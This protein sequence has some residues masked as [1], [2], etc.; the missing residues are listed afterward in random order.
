[1]VWTTANAG[2]LL[3]RVC[4]HTGL[5][6]KE[7]QNYSVMRQGKYLTL[8]YVE[9]PLMVPVKSSDGKRRIVLDEGVWSN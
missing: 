3:T 6:Q 5:L 7:S 2:G 8:Y 4:T 1:M 9:V